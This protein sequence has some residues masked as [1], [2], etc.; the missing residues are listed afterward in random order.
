VKDH[1][2]YGLVLAGGK[3]SRMGF[4][5]GLIPYHGTPQR[6]HLFNLL[7]EFC[8]T[9]FTSCHKSQHVPLSFNPV[10]DFFEVESPLNGI[11]SAFQLF[12]KKAWLTVAVDMPNVD[13]KVLEFL[14]ASRNRSKTATCFY[15]SDGINPEPLLTIWEPAAFSPLMTFIKAGNISPREFLLKS[16]IALVKLPFP[17][18]LENIN[19][20]QDFEKGRYTPIDFNKKEGK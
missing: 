5:K 1:D 17:Q 19:S 2:L 18:A 10:Y 14:T 4:D 9:V 20:T 12:S 11:L 3:S 15:D 6:E 16:D 7:S 8:E 13:K